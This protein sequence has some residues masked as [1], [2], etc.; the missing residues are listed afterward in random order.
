M[1]AW[2]SRGMDKFLCED[3]GLSS[4]NNYGK[5][6][7]SGKNIYKIAFL[8][9]TDKTLR[10][11]KYNIKENLPWKEIS[12][13][14]CPIPSYIRVEVS[15]VVVR[16][17]EIFVFL[18]QQF[19][20]ILYN[21]I[22]IFDI[23]KETWSVPPYQGYEVPD[24]QRD[25]VNRGTCLVGDDFLIYSSASF[26]NYYD[27]R[28]PDQGGTDRFASLLVYLAVTII[29]SLRISPGVLVPLRKRLSK[30]GLL[31]GFVFFL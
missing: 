9:E 3:F 22:P 6:I 29:R 21:F 26:D 25:S 14:F 17:Q 18:R 12:S 1:A 13:F 7:S 19:G 23:K 2:T 5:F 31:Q 4:I 24:L 16:G 11:W 10:I 8:S 15:E 28:P 20:K 27:F 30:M